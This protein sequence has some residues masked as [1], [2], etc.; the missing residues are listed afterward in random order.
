MAGFH[1]KLETADGAPADPPT[2][3]SAIP[4]WAAGDAITLGAGRRLVVLAVRENES[5][6]EMP[7]LVVDDA[8]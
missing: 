3:Q 4:G 6:E 7:V 2:F 5:D 8:A 1:F